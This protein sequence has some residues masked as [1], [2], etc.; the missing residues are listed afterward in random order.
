[1]GT[2]VLTTFRT[3]VRAALADTGTVFTNAIVDAAIFEAVSDISRLAPRELVHIEVMHSRT[4]TNENFTNTHGTWVDLTNKPID[5]QQPV[6][7]TNSGGGTTYVEDTDYII[8]YAQGRVQSLSTGSMTNSA[9]HKIDYEKS[10][11]GIDLSSLTD[12]I[13]I[14]RLEIAKSGGSPYQAYSSFWQWGDILWLQ[15]RDES[16]SP[17]L[18]ENDHVRVWY[19]AEHTKPGASAGSYPAYMDDVIVKGAVAYALF[20]KHRERNLQAVTDLATARTQLAIADDDQSAINALESGVIIALNL[21]DNEAG[22]IDTLEAAITTAL[23]SAKA[24]LSA[25]DT[26]ITAASTSAAAATTVLLLVDAL[27]DTPLADA[28]TALDAA[29]V[30]LGEME[31]LVDAAAYTT[32]HASIETAV[33]A[34]ATALGLV[35]AL[36]DTPLADA[37]VALDAGKVNLLTDAE[38]VFDEGGF[39]GVNAQI[40][41][42][43]DD[44]AVILDASSSIVT[45]ILGKVVEHLE[46]D[47]TNPD[48]AENQLKTGDALINATNLG[49][50]APALYA[51][52]SEAQVSIAR[53][54]VEE[55]SQRIAQARG[56]TEE[57]SQRIAH[58]LSYMTEVDRRVNIAQTYVAEARERLGIAR[59]INETVV[60]YSL[61]AQA[62][63]AQKRGV[64]DEVDARMTR[65]GI[66]IAEARERLAIAQ[67]LE[68]TALG[69]IQ[70]SQAYTA[71]SQIEI[72][73]AQG[74]INE[75]AGRSQQIDRHLSL[76]TLYIN[77]ASGWGEQINRH[78]AL[79]TLYINQSRIYQEGADREN[80]AA[81]R[82]LLDAQE[83]HAD[84][85]THLASRLEMSW[86]NQRATA[87][88]QHPS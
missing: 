9:T 69:H 61:E 12:F 70:A 52:Y 67:V 32:I 65:A 54:F 23:D 24:S 42:A 73:Q 21:A 47:A 58:R 10:L 38:A 59:T 88:K 40:E 16:G 60:G 86:P 44:A 11:R 17:N 84:Y 33:D 41:T 31:T 35:D 75:A 63:T 76:G 57:A 20:S 30:Q 25:A 14:D 8:D 34:M 18:A 53:G 79:G 64:L 13:S 29:I 1:M 4:V 71:A 55:A 28:E 68:Q 46:S 80:Q 77:Q 48:S 15:D 85:W 66:L 39:T 49:A 2:D 81:D 82:F 37:E 6:V 5:M 36:A 50:D 51:R 56:H 19:K 87:V 22:A 62:R 72:N 83:R 26:P 7:V 43:L 74:Y 45:T 3:N 27:A 78:L